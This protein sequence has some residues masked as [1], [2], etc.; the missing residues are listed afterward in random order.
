MVLLRELS[1]RGISFYTN[2]SSKKGK[3]ILTNPVVA[4]NFFW[5]W[6]ERQVRAQG[7]VEKLSNE[8]SD[9][10][11]NSRPRES[12]IGALASEQSARLVSREQ[13]ESKVSELSKA[14]EGKKI[15]RPEH[16]GGYLVR[17]DY[18][19]FWQGRPSR[20]HDRITYTKDEKKWVKAR[21]NP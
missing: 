11:F 2:Y 13:L 16:W 20:L 3:D 10:Y 12:Q 19:E 6:M 9:A 1:E 17:L 5:P 21:L 18:V 14:Y 15:P 8:E 4:V 7:K